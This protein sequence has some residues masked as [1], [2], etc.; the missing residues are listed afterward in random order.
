[1]EWKGGGGGGGGGGRAK[2]KSGVGGK[3]WYIKKSHKVRVHV[4]DG[5]EQKEW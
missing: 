1:M 3:Q 4:K 2:R 5:S